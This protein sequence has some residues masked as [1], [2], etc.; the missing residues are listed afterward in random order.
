MDRDG[1]NGACKSIFDVLMLFGW[2]KDDSE[3]HMEQV[4]LPVI[5]DKVPK[6]EIVIEELA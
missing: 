1:A 5:V 6:T 3:R 4:V 2:A